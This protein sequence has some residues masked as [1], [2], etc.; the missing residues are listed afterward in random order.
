ML[1][2]ALFLDRD[3]VINEDI[4]Y[5]HRPEDCRFVPGIFA[6]VRRARAASM[7]VVVVTNQA[8]IARGYYTESQFHAFMD[9]MR[10]QFAHESAPLDAVYFC[11]HHPTAGQ[12][13]YRQACSCRKPAPGMLLQAAADLALDMHASLLVGDNPSDLE[14]ARRAGV[15]R[16]WLLATPSGLTATGDA[17]ARVHSLDEIIP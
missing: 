7:A 6:L 8:G 14:A 10:A 1:R 9:W 12:G 16:A 5:C 15:G 11:P 17:L 2:P 4:A 13:A 3:G